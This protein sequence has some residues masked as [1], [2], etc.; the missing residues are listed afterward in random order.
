MSSPARI[1]VAGQFAPVGLEQALKDIFGD[2]TLA[3]SKKRLVIPSYNLDENHVYLFKTPHHE[4][5]KRDWRVPMWKVARATSAAPTYF[6]AYRGVDSVRLID[7]GVWANN[8][9]MVGVIEAVSML[10]IPLE[11]I[12]LLSMGT[13]DEVLA[14]P[15]RLDWGGLGVW[16]FH[17]SDVI[18]RAQAHGALTQAMHAIGKDK[19][20]RIDPKVPQGLFKMDKLST[21][22]HLAKA[23]Y[24]SR[25]FAPE[26]ERHFM[27]HHAPTFEPVHSR[28]KGD[29]K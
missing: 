2:A 23:A 20:L 17:A 13:T 18:L 4:R 8:P 29:D 9:C 14:K 22:E 3:R 5:L 10:D 11:Q 16:A 26:F 6:S 24:W 19:V 27:S 7:G 25:Q 21:S 28:M 1:V 15:R 12:S